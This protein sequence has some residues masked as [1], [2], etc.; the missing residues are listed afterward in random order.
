MYSVNLLLGK[1]MLLPVLFFLY[2][3]GLSGATSAFVGTAPADNVAETQTSAP[4]INSQEQNWPASFDAAHPLGQDWRQYAARD[5]VKPELQTPGRI[6][7]ESAKTPL[8]EGRT[9]ILLLTLQANNIQVRAVWKV[10]SALNAF[11]IDNGKLSLTADPNKTAIFVAT[12]YL[13]DNFQ[14]LNTAYQNLTASAVITVSVRTAAMVEGLSLAQ[15]PRLEVTTGVAGE[16]YVF[17]ASGGAMPHTYSLLHNPDDNAFYFTNG[18][19]SVN[20]SA[21]IGE[22]HFTV[23]IADADSMTV[24]VTATVEVVAAA[25]AV[26]QPPQL[27][28]TAGVAG[29]VYVFQ[30]SGGIMPHTY[31]LL[32]NPDDKAFYFNHGTLSV[33]ADATIDEY[34]FTVAVN[35]AASVTVTVAATVE[36]LERLQLLS[37]PSLTVTTSETR[38]VVYSFAPEDEVGNKVYSL[39]NTVAGFGFEFEGATL[40]LRDDAEAGLYT[41]SVLVQDGTQESRVSVTVLVIE[42]VVLSV[43]AVGALMSPVWSTFNGA[44]ATLTASGGNGDKLVFALVGDSEV[45]RLDEGSSTLSLNA[46][47][48]GHQGAATLSATVSVSDGNDSA[49]AVITV[50][51]SGALQVV[52]AGGLTAPVDSQYEGL[53]GSVVVLGGYAGEVSLT[54]KGPDAGKFELSDSLLNVQVKANSEQTLTVTLAAER[55]VEMSEREVLVTVTVEMLN[56]AHSQTASVVYGESSRAFYQL[57][58]SGGAGGRNYTIVASG[59]EVPVGQVAVIL[60]YKGNVGDFQYPDGGTMT[61][62]SLDDEGNLWAA[63]SAAA[64]EY[65]LM[66]E[67]SDNGLP[68]QRQTVSVVVNIQVSLSLSFGSIPKNV[69]ANTV[70]T[71]GTVSFVGALPEANFDFPNNIKVSIDLVGTIGVLQNGELVYKKLNNPEFL[72][73]GEYNFRI[74]VIKHQNVTVIS[75]NPFKAFYDRYESVAY[76]GVV[77]VEDVVLSVG[78]VGA[79]MSPV[80]STFNGAVATLTASGGN[81]DKLEFAL[82][83]DSEV[84]R[85]DE[86]SSTLSLN[87]GLRGHQGAATLSA[88]VSVSDGNDSAEA[89]ITVLVSGALQV[90][91]AGGLTA[92]VDSQ[93]EG[94]VGSVVVLGGYAGEVSLTLK[95]PDAGKFELSD[96]LLNVQVKAN[97]EQTLTVTLAAERGVEMSERE[98]LVT[99]TVEMLSV[100]HSQ[101]ASVVYG[102]SSRAFYQLEASGGAGGRNYTIV[103]SGAEVPAAGQVAAILRYKGNVGDFQYPDG[104]TMTVFS[105]DDEGNLWAAGSAAAGEYLLM[106]EV[107]D[108]GLPVQRQTVSVVV[109]IQVSLSLSF[110]SIPKNVAANTVYTFGTVS[111]VGALPEANFDFPNN[112]KVSIDLVGTIGVLQNGELVYKKPNNPEFLTP[113]EYN[114]RIDVIKHQNVTVISPNPFKAF[115][116]RYESVAYDGVVVVEDVIEDVVLAEVVLMSPVWSTFNGAVAT[117]TASGGNGDKL[118]FA[119]VGDSEVFRLDEGSST[120]SLNAGLRG[121]QGAATL[122]A[123]VRVSDGNDS[124]E[125]VITVLVS[126]ALQ[127]VLA[128]G[129]VAPVHAQYAGLVGSVVVVGG[130]A[131]EVSLTLSGA[132]KD[133][134]KLSGGLLSLSVNVSGEQTLT[135]TV[136]ASRGDETAAQEVVVAVYAP[137]GLSAPQEVVVTTHQRYT[138]TVIEGSGG[139]ASS[140]SYTLTS[141][142]LAG[143][144]INANNGELLLSLTVAALHTLTVELSDGA[145]SLP[146]SQ[147]ISVLV[148]EPLRDVSE[149]VLAVTLIEN[150]D[151][152][153]AYTFTLSGGIAPYSYTFAEAQSLSVSVNADSGVLSYSAGD[154]KPGVYTVTV[155]ADDAAAVTAPITLL[156]TVEVSAVLSVTLSDGAKDGVGSFVNLTGVLSAVELSGV[157]G[158]APYTFSLLANDNFAIDADGKNF[159]ITMAFTEAV[160][161]SAVWVLEDSDGRTPAVTGTVQVEIRDELGFVNNSPVV[162]VTVGVKADGV[163]YIAKAQKDEEA[164]YSQI[165]T[166]SSFTVSVSDSGEG[167]LV[168]MISTLSVAMTA[169]LTIKAVDGA[170]ATLILE[171]RAYDELSASLAAGFVGQ[172]YAGE[173]GA[174]GAVEVS[175]GSGD[176]GYALLSM[177]PGFEV[178]QGTLSADG[179]AT[180]GVHTLTV[181]VSDDELA[182]EGWVMVTVEATVSVGEAFELSEEVVERLSVLVQGGAE[183]TLLTLSGKGGERPYEYDLVT[184]TSALTISLSGDEGV[185]SRVAGEDLPAGDNTVVIVVSDNY[186]GTEPGTPDIRVTVI[187]SAVAALLDKNPGSRATVIVNESKEG[188]YSFEALGGYGDKTYTYAPTLGFSVVSDSGLLNYD[189]VSGK[190]GEVVLTVTVDDESSLTSA[191]ELLLTVGV[192]AALAVELSDGA[193]QGVVGYVNVAEVLSGVELSGVGGIPPYTFSLLANNNFAID[194]DGGNFR[195][196]TAFTDAELA[197]AV[198]VLEDSY[199]GT[200][201]VSGT[202]QVEIRNNLGFTEVSPMVAVLADKKEDEA[203]YTVQVAGADNVEYKQIGA[204]TLFTVDVSDGSVGAVV[205]MK[206]SLSAGMAATLTIEAARGEGEGAVTVRGT[207]TLEVRGYAML[208]AGLSGDF[209]G[210]TYTG[211]EGALGAVKVSGGSGDYDYSWTLPVAGF[212]DADGT[213]SV[214]GKATVGVYTVTVVVSDKILAEK[215]WEATTVEATVLVGASLSLSEIEERSALVQ[216]EVGEELVQVQ[217]SG[218]DGAYELSGQD[219]PSGL[220][221]SLLSEGTWVVKRAGDL[222]VG[223]NEGTVIIDDSYALTKPG[224]PALTA[225]LM[226]EGIANLVIAS[227]QTLTA[228]MG[229]SGVLA[230]LSAEG[231]T[232]AKVYKLSPELSGF[233]LSQAGVLSV[234]MDVAA[235]SHTLTVV[236]SDDTAGVVQAATAMV[237]VEVLERLQLLSVPSL[238][239]TTSETREV[240]YLFAAEGEVGNKTYFLENVG[241]GFGFEFEGATLVLRDDAEAGLYTLSVLAQDGTQESRVSVT[242]LVIEDVVLAVGALM[243]PVWSTFDGAVATLTASGGNGDKLEFA[244]MGDS[245]VFT[246]D[247]GSSTLSLNAGLRGHQGAATLSV[248]VSVSDGNDSAEAVITVLVSGALQVVL[249][250]L[251]SPVHAQYEGSVGSVV[252]LGGY[253]GK[254]SL[255]LSGADKDKFKLS[256]GGALSLQVDASEEQM[257]TVTVEASR[258]DEKAAQEVVVVVYAP[259]G[260]SVMSA[261]MVTTHK[262]DVLAIIEGS[263][264]DASSYSYTLTSPTLAGV[265]INADNGELLLSLTVAA[266][267]TLTVQLSD[268]ADSLPVSREISVLVI[269]PL[270]DISEAVLA[271]TLIE[272]VSDAAAYTFTLSGGIAPYSYTFAEAQSLSVSVNADSGV[273][274][275]SAG[276]AKPGVY[277]VTVSAD[278]VAAASAPITLLLTVEVSAVLTVELSDGAKDGVGSFVNFAGPVAGVELSGVGGIAPYTF[279]LLANDNFAIDADGKNF[280]II[281]AFTEA[282]TASV[283]WVLDDSDERT[284]AVTGTV[285][286]EIEDALGFADNKPMVNVTVEV[287]ADGVIYTAKAEQDEGATYKQIGRHSSFTVN[288]SNAAVGAVVSMTMALSEES[289]VTLTIEVSRGT[290]VALLALEVRAYKELS[291]GL[292]AGFVGQIYAGEEGA[293]GTVEVSGGSGSYQYDGTSEVN[294]FVISADGELNINSAERGVYVLTVYATDKILGDFGWVTVSARATVSVGAALSLLEIEERSALV[295]GEVGEELVQVQVSGGDG[296]YKLIGQDLSSGLTIS[297]LSEGTWVVKR[298]GNL[299]VGANVGTVII[300]DSYSTTNPGTPALTAVLTIVGIANFVPWVIQDMEIIEGGSVKLSAEGGTEAKT[301]GLSPKLGGFSL[302]PAGVLSVSVG[303][304]ADSYTLTVVVSDATTGAGQSAT[305]T[306]LVEVLGRLQLLSVLSLTVTTSE[307][308]DVVYSFDAKGGMDDK[309]YS[310]ENTVAGFGFKIDGGNLRWLG[311]AE[312]GLYTLSVLVADET[313]E[314]RVLVTVLVI[315]NVVLYV[316]EESSVWSSFNGALATLRAMGGNGDELVFA[317]VGDSQVFTLTE[318]GVLSLNAGLRGHQG[319]ATLSATVSVSDGNDSAEGVITVLVSGALQVS[320]AEGLTAPVDSQYEGLVGSVVVLGGY[321]GEVSLTL[322]GADKDKFELSG[323]SLSLSVNVSKEQ[324]LTVTVVAS[325]GDETAAQEVVVSVYAPLVLSVGALMSPVWSTFDGAVATLTASGGN[326]DE[327]VFVLVG[328]SQVFTLTAGSSTLSLNAGL[329]GHQGAAT[330]SVTVSVSDGNDS[331]EAVITVLVSGALQVSLAEG[332][333]APV[334]AQY[335]GLVGSVVVLG[336]YAGDVSLTL[337]GADKDKFE[338]SGGSLSLSVNVSKE[339]TLTVTVVASRGDETAAQE[340]VV[341]V[342]APLV[343]SVGALMS[344]VWSTFDGAVATLT[345]SGGNGDELVFVLVG[346]SQV[347]TLTAGSS[348]LS[349]NAGLRGH[350]GAAT[351]SATVSVSDGNDSAEGVIT[352]LVSGALQVSLAEGLTAPVDSQYEGLVGSVV[353]VGGYAGDVSLTLSGA[354][355]GKFELSGRSLSLSVNV[356]KEQTLTVTVVASRGDETAAQEVVVSVY[357]PLV[358]SV[359]AL[360]SPVWS[361]F[362]GAVATLTAS[363]GNGDKLVFVLVGTSQVFTLTAGSSTLSL[364]A[365]LRGHQGAAT[366]SVTV[367]VSDGNDS[368]EAVITVLVSGALQVS[369]AEGLT[370]P[371]HAQYEGLVGSVVVLG[372]Y[373]GDVSLTL[374]GADKD[375]FELSGGSLS[376]S[377]NVSKEQTLTVTVVASRGDETAAQEVVVS[378]AAPLAV[379]QPQRLEATEGIAKE[380]YVF[381]AS[382][383]VMPHTY[384]LLH[385]PDDNAFYFTHGTLSVNADATIGKYRFT[386]KVADATSATVTVTA[387]VEIKGRQ[388]FVLG[389]FGGGQ[390]NDVWSSADSKNWV[391]ITAAGWKKRESHQA[392]SHKG[393]LYVLGGDDGSSL[394]DVWSS[395]D[396][397]EWEQETDDADWTK[398]YSHQAVSHNERLYVLGGFDNN[399]KQL[400]DVWSSP[401]GEEWKQETAHANWTMR[402]GHQALSHNGRLYVLGGYAGSSLNDVWS[403]AD[404]KNWSRETA[405]ANWTMRTFHQALSHNGRLYVLGGYDGSQ[406][407]NDVWSSADGKNWSR[408]PDNTRWEKRRWH[409]AVSHHGRLYVL[410]GDGDSL[411]NDVWSSAD[412][413]EWA[414]ITIS[415]SWTGRSGHQAVVFPPELVLWGVGEKLTVTAG[416]AED[417]HTFTA[418][419]GRGDYS[420]SLMPKV[421]G[422]AVSPDGV[423]SA[424]SNATGGEYTLTVWVKDDADKMAQSALRVLVNDLHLAEVPRLF[425]VVGIAKVL[426]TIYSDGGIPG[427]Q[428]TIVSG[429]KEYFALDADSGILSLLTTAVEGVYTLSVE[430]SDSSSLSQKATAVATVSVAGVLAVAQPQRL[431]ATEGVAKEVYVFQASGGI[432]PHTYMLLHNPDD[433]AF[434]FTNGTLS[435]NADATI[436]EYRFTV[437]VSDA[438]ST[439]VTVTATVE[440]KGSQIFVLGGN[441]GKSLNDVWFSADGQNWVDATLTAAWEERRFHQALSHHGRLYVL[442]GY[443]GSQSLNDVWSSADGKNWS[444][445]PDNTRWE[446]RRWHQ[447]VSHHGR[448]YVLGG[449]GDSLFNDVWSLADGEEWEQETAHADWTMRYGHQAVSH[450]GRLYVL[451]GYD[452]SKRLNDVWSSADGKNWSQETAHADWTMRRWHQA[453]SHHG[454]LYVL[455]GDDGNRRN[456]VWSSADGKNWSR[457]TSNEWT[458]RALHQALSHQGRL[459]VLG[460]RDESGRQNDVWSLADGEEW[461]LITINASWT[462]RNGHQAVVFPPELVLWGVGERLTATAGIAEDLHTFTAQYG[463]SDYSYSLMPKVNG[464]AVSPGGVLSAQSNVTGGEYTLTVWV[465][466]DADNLAQTAVK[467]FVAHLHLAE[468]PRLFGVVGIAKVLHTI[469]SDGGIPGAQY[470]IVSGHKEYFALDADSGVL[471]LLTT[472]VEGVYTLSVEASDSSSLSQKATAVATVSVAGVLAVAQPQRL[473]ATEGVAKEVYVFQAS[474]GIMPHTYTLLH[475]PDDDAFYFTHGTLSVNADATMGEYRFTVAVSDAASTAVTVAATVEIKGRQIFVL[476][477]F[478]DN[479]LNDVWSSAD[480]Q[481]WVDATL[482]AAWE[483][484]RFHQALSHHGRLYV[485]GG[486]DGSQ[487]LNDVWSSAD[488]KNWSREPDNTRWE[489]RRWHQAVSHHGRLYVLGGDGDS[490]FNDVW[491]LADGEEW[492]QETAHADWTMRYGHQAVSHNGRLYVLGGYDGSKRL[493]DVWSS[494]DG[495]N[496]S[497]ETAHADWTMRRWHQAVSHHGRLYV[498]GGD[499]GNRRNDVW[500]SADGKNWSRETSNEWTGRALHQALSHQGRLYVLGGRDD[501]GRQNDVWSLA[502]G[503]EWALI[504]INASWTG[505]N[506]HQAVVFP[507]ELILWGVGE[508][509]T[510]SAGIAEDLHTFTAQYGR[511]DYSYSLMPKVNGFAVSPDGVLSAQSNVIGGEY[512]LTVWVKDDA[513]KMAQSALRVLVNDFHLAEVPSLF[514]FAGIAKVLHTIYS[515]GGIP[516]AQYTIV[517]GHK[518]YFALD[519]DSGILSLLTTA[520][521]GV[522]TLSVEVSDSLFLSRKATAVATVVVAVPLSV[523]QPQRL[524]A[525]EGI[526]KEVYVFKASGGVMPH[527]Y[528]LLHNPDDDAFYFTH[529]TLSVNADATIGEYR[530]TVAVSDAASATVTVAATVE[531]KGRQIFVLGGNDDDNFGALNAL[532]DVWSSADS[533][534]WVSITAAGLKKRA[535]HQA[536]S[537]KGRLYVLG[538]DDGDDR[539]KDVWSSADGKNWSLETDDAGWGK[540]SEHQALSHN[541]R[542]YVLG[543]YGDRE[544]SSNYRNDVWSSADGKNWSRE[545]AHANWT[546]RSSHQA[547]SHN[548]RLYVLGGSDDGKLLYFND[549]WSSADGKNWSLETAD[550]DW[551]GRKWYQALSHNGRLYVLG[552][553][554]RGIAV[555]AQNDVWSSADG[556][557]WSLETARADWDGRNSHQALSLND[558]LYVLG[559]YGDRENGSR[560]RND[561]WSSADGKNWS[562]ETSRADWMMRDL[563]QAVVFPPELVLWGVG[564]RLTVSAGIAEDLHTFTAQYGRG[565]YSYS[566]SPAVNGFAV[567]PGGVLSAQSDTTGGEYTLTVWVKDDADKMA[568]TALRVLVNDFHLAEVPLLFGFAGIAKVLHTITSGGV[569]PGAQYTIVAGHKEYFALDADSGVLSLLTTAVAGVYT[570]SVEVSDSSSLSQKATAV[571]TVSV[572]AALVVAQPQRLEATEGIA[573][574]VYV[575]QA[576]GGVMPHTYTLLHNPDDDAF[577]FTHGTLS[578]NADATIGEYRFTV[579]VSDAASTAVTVAATVEIKGRQIFVLGGHDGSNPLNDAWSSA[580]SKNWVSITANARWVKRYGHQAL[581]HKGRLYVLGGHTGRNRLNDV[582]SSADGKN[583]S[584]ETND[585]KWPGRRWHQ[586]LSHNGRLYVLGGND[587]SGGRNDVWSSENGKTWSQ[588]TAHANWTMRYG[589]QALSHNGR[590]YVLGGLGG[591]YLNDVW[592]SADGKNWSQ[593]T[594]HANWTMRLGH[595]ALSH[596]G[597]LYVLGGV[598]DRENGSRYRNDVWS[599]A[600]GKNWVE[601]TTGNI[602]WTGRS[603]YQALSHNDRIYV[604][605]GND[606]DD[607][608]NDVWS[609]AD[610]EEWALITISASWSGRSNHQAVVFPPELILWGVGE[611]LTVSAGIAEDLHTFTAQYGRGDYS[612]SLMPKVNGFAVSPDG[613]LSAQ[614]DATGGEYTLTVWVK[615]DA[616]KMAQTALRVLVNDFHLAEVP[617]LFGVVGSA[618]VL[619][620]ITSGGVIPGAQYTIVAGHKEYFAL[621]TDS[622]VLSLLTTAVA[623][624]YTLSVEVSDS[625]SLSRKATAVATVEVAALGQIF[626]LGGYDGDRLND[627][628]SSANG[629]NWVSIT[630]AGWRK[631]AGHQ[632]LSHNGRLYV[633]GGVGGGYLN[634]VWSS[635][636]GK[637][638]SQ[639][640]N[641]ANWTMRFGYQAISHNGRLYVLGGRYGPSSSNLLNDVWSSANGKNWSLETARAD[642][643]MRTD[644]QA[645]S[646]NGRLYVLGGVG[647]GYLNDVW[648]SA[649]GKNWSQETAHADWTMRRGHQALSH[650]GRLYVLGGYDGDHLNDVWSSA[651]GKN[652]SRETGNAKWTGRERHQALSLNDRLYVL[653]GYDYPNHLND[654]WSSADGEEWA[655]ITISASWTGRSRHQAVVFPPELVLWSVG[656]RLTVSAGIAAANLHTFTARYGK[657][658]YS[659]SLSPAVNGFAVSPGGVLSAGSNATVGEYTLIVWVEDAAGNRAQTALRVEVVAQSTAQ[660]HPFSP[661]SPSRSPIISPS[662]SG[663]GASALALAGGAL[664]LLSHPPRV[665]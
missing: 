440:I 22:Y 467:V 649:D 119:L 128:D 633:L 264:G 579:A 504:T 104:G 227:P 286:V 382:G 57:E 193:R 171:V 342:Y 482:T 179:Q 337:S 389:G 598:G 341:S 533:K 278:D 27:E 513:D 506:G 591:G 516:G 130:Y 541:G 346:T 316:P 380:V 384:M 573:K 165:G 419:Y 498:L 311:D 268:G 577:Y 266:S 426:H 446:K 392:L 377:V 60:R 240:V 608:R 664:S 217:V 562:L 442:G 435:V 222:S 483:E 610:G 300:D 92:P 52:L 208:S 414:L 196:I 593:E 55:G 160:T 292:A 596:N 494:A 365:G 203:I 511:S 77:V 403:S 100:A 388:I 367:S 3:V 319:A 400:N 299:S 116:D 79:L 503:E 267:Y 631:R 257:L 177:V 636:D 260:L 566:L 491:S 118:E 345:A 507:P 16:V 58:A 212:A 576:S 599:S 643:T 306:L 20:V 295:Q 90:V 589:H 552:G 348:T 619:H 496:W 313:Q 500:S 228:T 330:L 125:A 262:G 296:A 499:D 122:S 213:L 453:V 229:V 273:L 465:K 329:R 401:D 571:A 28:V 458:G 209:A 284:P 189:G 21:T 399:F 351:L 174:L 41:L 355:A 586:A 215:G 366:L 263:G 86:G 415:A 247:E 611:R 317:L 536:L 42:D 23:A 126:G 220:T 554:G 527:T 61:V 356:S 211:E 47:L 645:L 423:L 282:V 418:Q 75:P 460:G 318:Y 657:G 62:F 19:L 302:S 223:A 265:S 475:N 568:Q 474:G 379:A 570:L 336:G 623:G 289:T 520:V 95:G 70:Y 429:H 538:G 244:L 624:I 456:D 402:Y 441:D 567:S 604:L 374:S 659:Y 641:N 141:P 246:L 635:P 176:Y 343:L 315:E 476:G 369:L 127:V 361:T 525:T 325:R 601:E 376:L 578:V 136:E 404:G 447:A 510:V 542:L 328:T 469:Y 256:D 53:V 131:G 370:A 279:T 549:V 91:L 249:E 395:P 481:N 620:T 396:G 642:W 108:N 479:S 291:L 149:A 350:Q 250:D 639:E 397:E 489:K 663:G 386:V 398:R 137:L 89:V 557:N 11:D 461:A 638:W 31:T 48:R 387:T 512:T 646:H 363:G 308:Q 627:V 44:V 421:N 72:T 243:S 85:L 115:Y 373:A 614:S 459:Y 378:V 200:P 448:L 138:L 561:V 221:I 182:D 36:V 640:T 96:S 202:V 508:R 628:W 101:T 81:G 661:I 192:S 239:V 455:G 45:F 251:I 198:W 147:E 320:L 485:L 472:A 9:T 107:S 172:T 143:V 585:A 371:V 38:E 164:T 443:D 232:E 280:R 381:Q 617:R 142:T 615:D 616:D 565:D 1:R 588:E 634:D 411:F 655:L 103:A 647:G 484:R 283:A 338:L 225:V 607:R 167:A 547:L 80:W 195:I 449:D 201:A 235:R 123:T 54:L 407:L 173:T 416:I 526:A 178:S 305:A 488:G 660:S 113:G 652:W 322:S 39:E 230:E 559:G 190:V 540:R 152:A 493:N 181:I 653:G 120:L 609:S 56:V 74:D 224:T 555:V 109:N 340:V 333:T 514:G 148:I 145:G 146:V 281:T 94:L 583:W 290:E 470:T 528:T 233:S 522:Y 651:D 457:E 543:G 580:D 139:D 87:A 420:Y 432:M 288:V 600:D 495:K 159:R 519:A 197:A 304:D 375:K 69:A 219:L 276:D 63:G 301:Y 37:V 12:V 261:V 613:V 17:E 478:N 545:T 637:N 444:L 487:S 597:R 364:N 307:T 255:T 97:S 326:G 521:E 502:D 353:V 621:D 204:H 360:M 546:M 497:Q 529:G 480:G 18:T 412:G 67:V 372:G 186:E 194:E 183:V 450:N 575:F 612:Y 151:D 231:G 454:R 665:R 309:I 590:L 158:I 154:A 569:I 468:V 393:R 274:S 430:A 629:Q 168:S 294:V 50:L 501:R 43:G 622:G 422:F 259:L 630:A 188:V 93:Y 405:H 98:V 477:G 33:N 594:A 258:G 644:H 323:G 625:S 509:L 34:R 530:F 241:A 518:E 524:E 605:G 155:S 310:L 648:S 658:D 76:D 51:V 206:G 25:L 544:K 406:S 175:G 531:I 112:I 214:D 584:R 163:L 110:G 124:A 6:V 358:L 29:E 385:N 162:N 433:N 427:A 390:L 452:G 602:R 5:E 46:G 121:H 102:E 271:V 347:F 153:A 359:G 245:E 592:S 368:A 434:Y 486:Y 285:R 431:E 505:R 210:Q 35:D 563:H 205:S 417:L 298:A 218:G 436:G 84:F 68:V 574:E 180:V 327:L 297:L 237:L 391:S 253:A 135:V 8:T 248:T 312:A 32:H 428:Y 349:L 466:D 582:W 277:T 650:N 606:G 140:Y 331:A 49:E 133:K 662:A 106:V 134:F 187:L 169:T 7:L 238:T 184:L 413:E 523:A 83:G 492:E 78:A 558:R 537:H 170:A 535:G 581:S 14:L 626:V 114:F 254:V 564:E 572:A 394:N 199:S 534:K 339:Q 595:Q 410:G 82:V 439:A 303:A 462:G 191:E 105:L 185:L 335:E 150:V 270:R 354:D 15:P 314:S 59:A 73:P 157:G 551:K 437:A 553:H 560:L 324:T 275:Y 425:G 334:H 65:L 464:F 13:I 252:V 2:L 332:L 40:V 490:L 357:A 321:A 156:L 64:G 234:S 515:D 4:P 362:N 587:D 473:E 132:D 383:G 409:Q 216:G 471:S 10:T 532:N 207:L 618:K 293:L 66:V 632:A 117:L 344:P 242:V 445:E 226:I 556:K 287:E 603:D 236:V 144:S 438:A 550:A 99:V 24:T 129:L 30:A 269:E 517:A 166:H 463:R 451:G 539:L 111:F 548:G 161:V 88:T 408:E 26:A 272:D 654:V 424:Q 656:E 352:V 71:F